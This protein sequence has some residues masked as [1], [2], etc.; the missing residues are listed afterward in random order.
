MAE[1]GTLY[2]ADSGNNR[3]RKVSP[4]GIIDS[5]AGTGAAGLSGDKGPALDAQY[6]WP[7]DV[8]ADKDGNVYI[9]DMRNGTVRVVRPL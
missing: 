4:D 2:I 8:V 3:V 6:D 5:I 1:D 9:A 7:I